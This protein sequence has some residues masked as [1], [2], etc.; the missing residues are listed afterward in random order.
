[1][2]LTS[3]HTCMYRL[4]FDYNTRGGDKPR[5]SNMKSQRVN[6]LYRCKLLVDATTI[7]HNNLVCV[8]IWIMIKPSTGNQP[9]TIVNR[10]PASL[11]GS[12]KEKQETD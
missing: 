9:V 6:L 10:H 11:K 1:M 12:V 7:L 4:C 5:E 8:G 2:L 3:T